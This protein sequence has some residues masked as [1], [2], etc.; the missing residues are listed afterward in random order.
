MPIDDLLMTEPS[1]ERQKVKNQVVR[2]GLPRPDFNP[3]EARL[4]AFSVNGFAGIQAVAGG[5]RWSCSG[6]KFVRRV[7]AGVMK[8][9]GRQFC[10]YRFVE[11]E[12]RSTKKEHP[13]SFE[14]SI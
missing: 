1:Q 4:T 2:L 8:P 14:D 9:V 12:I 3:L 6:S 5:R 10:D 11:P 7:D 13:A